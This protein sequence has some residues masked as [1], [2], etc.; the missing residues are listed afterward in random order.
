[1]GYIENKILGRDINSATGTAN[2]T[3]YLRGDDSWATPTDTGLLNVVEDTTPQLGGD[4]ASN[5]NDINFGDNDKG[6][7]GAGND[8]QIYHDGSN[9]FIS[10]TGTGNLFI[11]ASNNLTL[12]SATGENYLAGVADGSVTLYHNA[13]AKLATTTA[14][15]DVT[16]TVVCDGANLQDNELVRPVLKDYAEKCNNLGAISGTTSINMESGNYITATISGTTTF[17]FDNPYNGSNDGTS[18]TLVLTN[19]GA[20]TVNW[21]VTVDWHDATAPTLTSSGVDMLVFTTPND[22]STWYGFIAGQAMA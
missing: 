12:E 22:G 20:S 17:T 13:V 7:F 9:S 21:P 6:Q 3:T 15:M 14:G 19:G 16:G 1:M 18:F 5:G 10:D 8:L 2:T 4:L 11:K